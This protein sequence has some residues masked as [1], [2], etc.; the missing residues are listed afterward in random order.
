MT[1]RFALRLKALSSLAPGGSLRGGQFGVEKESLRVTQDGYI[2]AAPHFRALGSALTN[3]YI[4]TDYSEALLEFVTPPVQ[5]SWETIQFL[6]DIHQFVYEAIGE[7]LL[8]A[9]SMPCMIRSEADIPLANYGT[10]NVGTMKTVYR[11]GLGHRYGRRMQAISGIHFNYSLPE[12]FWPNYRDS[13][14]SRENDTDFRSGAYLGLVR[15]VRRF[16]WILLYLFGASPAV[17]KSFLSGVDTNLTELDDGTLYGRHATSLRM[18][19]IG[20]QHS[21]QA[22][23]NVSA[24]NLREYIRDLT[25]AVRTPYPEYQKI[26]IKVGS[27]YRQLN[28]NRLQIENEYYSTIRPKR[29]AY[30]GER[31]TQA[32]QRR[33]VEYVELRALDVSPFDPVGIN[34]RQIKFL[35]VFSIYCLLND[36][37][38][39][40]QI[41]HENNTHNR[42]IVAGRGRE[43]GLQLRRDGSMLSLRAWGEEICDGMLSV[44]EILDKESDQGYVEAIRDQTEAVSDA[45]LTPSA[46][47]ISELQKTGQP[48]F[49]YA[50]SLS[51]GHAEYFKELSPDLN[52]HHE[53]LHQESISSLQ[54]QVAIEAED[55]VGFEEYLH[56]YFR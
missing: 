53:M 49:S 11:R 28:A 16:D 3:R 43:P 15:N 12:L 17:C 45:D 38:P 14:K 21:N 37:P 31:A 54:R 56:H 34:Q 51:R 30:S 35:E 36:S 47:L 26:G 6:C 13:E 18:S 33:G 9:V 19:N 24:N 1:D 32:L 22:S 50:M 48:M 8:W 10:S 25:Q 7:E 39:I 52:V 55:D 20:Y 41:E 40:D 46:L 2:S 5:S 27:E 29:V 42:S 23:L 44:A 4:T